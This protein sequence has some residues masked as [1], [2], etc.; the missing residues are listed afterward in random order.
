MTDKT[1]SVPTP[2]R[3]ERRVMNGGGP[4]VLAVVLSW[5]YGPENAPMDHF[6]IDG[7]EVNALVFR[8]TMQM[9]ALQQGPAL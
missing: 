2:K 5:D 9:L 3:I 4:V 7:L 1:G 6:F 8:L